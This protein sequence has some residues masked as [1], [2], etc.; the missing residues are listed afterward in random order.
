MTIAITDDDIL[1]DTESFTIHL[2]KSLGLSNKFTIEP[3]VKVIN[4]IDNDTI[5]CVFTVL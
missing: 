3:S 4:I 1:E 2:Q 5:M